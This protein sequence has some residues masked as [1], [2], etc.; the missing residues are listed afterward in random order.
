MTTTAKDRKKT[1]TF[2]DTKNLWVGSQTITREEYYRRMENAT[3]PYSDSGIQK[4][5]KSFKPNQ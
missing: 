2:Q 3:R 5:R 1:P 4:H